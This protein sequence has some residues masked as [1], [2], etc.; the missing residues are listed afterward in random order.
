MGI[1]IGPEDVTQDL[2]PSV[3]ARIFPA[4]NEARGGPLH[5]RRNGQGYLQKD[6]EPIYKGRTDAAWA[7]FGW[8]RANVELHRI[9]ADC[10]GG[11]IASQRVMLKCG[12]TYEGTR[13]EACWEHGRFVDIKQFGLL[14]REHDRA[15]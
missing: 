1:W 7:M 13:R 5:P 9:Q 15:D 12:F 6:C 4:P 3:L 11:N 14:K 2:E 10:T 8:L